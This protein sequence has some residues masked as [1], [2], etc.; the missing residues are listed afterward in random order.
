MDAGLRLWR[1]EDELGFAAFL[2]DGVVAGDGDLSE[3]L[4][5]R[6]HA[7][8][9]DQGVDGIGDRCHGH[10][11]GEPDDDQSLEKILDSGSQG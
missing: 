4:S 1:T 11:G 5:I 6:S 9:E 7:R 3:G 2:R 8:A 10:H